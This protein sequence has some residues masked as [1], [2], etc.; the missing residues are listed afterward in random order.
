MSFGL[1]P[2][3][4]ALLLLAAGCGSASLKADAGGTGG[5]GGAGA[6]GSG[7]GGTVVNDGGAGSGAGGAT[8][9]GGAAV[10][11]AADRASTPDLA[12]DA[13]APTDTGTD[14]GGCNRPKTCAAMHTCS[15]TTASGNYLIFPDG[16]SDA[17]LLVHCD[18]ET[19]GGGWTVIYLADS[20]NLNSDAIGYTVPTQSL[21]DTAQQ[22][23]VGF[24]NLNLNQVISD[25]AS[26]DLPVSWRLKNP[27]AV[28]PFEELTIPVSVNGG[29]PGPALVRYGVANFG[30]LC[31]DTWVT[32]SNYGRFC[33]QG[34]AAAFYSGFSVDPPTTDFCALSNQ[35]YTARVCSDTARFSIAVR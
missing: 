9:A 29:L 16:A 17:G 8:G 10:D 35:T 34:T 11:A 20:V 33:V 3:L 19:A 27:L 14:A 5:A 26:F 31:A 6:G 32:V 13:P 7:T 24:R 21:R 30:A 28:S 25:W 12:P 15:P 23:L 4:T 22:T 2:L 1:A 18:M